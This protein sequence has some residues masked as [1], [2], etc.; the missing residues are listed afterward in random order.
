MLTYSIGEELGATEEPGIEW[1]A[2][3]SSSS[4]ERRPAMHWCN[5][6][7]GWCLGGARGRTEIPNMKDELLL[8]NWMT[9][10]VRP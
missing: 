3:S 6:T 10:P 7:S 2:F 4:Q 5:W 8:L 9:W 1:L